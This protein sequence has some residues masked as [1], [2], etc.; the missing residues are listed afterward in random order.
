M[1]SCP[2]RDTT[3]NKYTDLPPAGMNRKLREENPADRILRIHWQIPVSRHQYR[4]LHR[5]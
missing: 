3:L 4:W 1:H 5:K 2:E